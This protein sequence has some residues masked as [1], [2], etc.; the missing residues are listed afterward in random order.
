MLGHLVL[1][2]SEETK[3]CDATFTLSESD[4]GQVKTLPSELIANDVFLVALI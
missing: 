2:D 4:T 1:L 3:I